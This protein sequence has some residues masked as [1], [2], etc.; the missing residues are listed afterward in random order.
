M[1]LLDDFND[2]VA[3]GSFPLYQRTA[4]G[5]ELDMTPFVKAYIKNKLREFGERLKTE[6]KKVPQELGDSIDAKIDMLTLAGMNAGYNVRNA[7]LN[8]QIEKELA[9]L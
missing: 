5:D 7:E 9:D 4:L 8:Q 6:N 2:K 3:S 1:K